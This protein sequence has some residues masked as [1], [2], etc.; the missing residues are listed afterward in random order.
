MLLLSN[1]KFGTSPWNVNGSIVD[2]LDDGDIVI[3]GDI[4]IDG[5]TE[6]ARG[7]PSNGSSL[8]INAANKTTSSTTIAK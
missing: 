3:V 1:R 7:G 8:S 6:V 4:V 2:G 5:A